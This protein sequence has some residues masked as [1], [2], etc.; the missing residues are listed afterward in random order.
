MEGAEKLRLMQLAEQFPQYES[1]LR[2]IWERM[3]D[4]SIPFNTGNVYDIRMKGLYSLKTL[5]PLFS[6]YSYDDLKVTNGID[7][8][9]K[10]REYCQAEGELKTQIYQEL[11]DYCALDTYGEYIVLHALIDEAMKEE[12]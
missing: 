1:Q 9:F 7:A 3:I 11:T 12:V 8:I 6:N 5:V 2:Q 10:W 4:L